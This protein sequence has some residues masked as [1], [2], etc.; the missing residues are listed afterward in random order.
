[1]KTL[2]ILTTIMIAF[3]LV[4]TSC[5][6]DDDF[7]QDNPD[8]PDDTVIVDDSDDT[9]NLDQFFGAAATRSFFGQV[10]D[11]NNNGI[12]GA[13]VHVGTQMVATDTNGIFSVQNVSVNEQFAYLR[14]TAFGYVT[15]GR[16]LRPTDGVN[17]VKV[18]LLSADVT[19]TVTSGVPE[20]VQLG[21]GTSVALPGDYIDENGNPYTGSVDVILDFLDPASEDLDAVM[22]GMLYAEDVAGD[23]VYLETF[24]MISVELRDAS[25]NELNIDPNSPAE[26]RFPLDPAL[27]G[28]APAT[29]PLWSFDDELGYWI[30]DGEATLQGNEYVGMVSH[31][32]FWNCDAPF[33]VVDFCTTVLDDNGNPLANTTV[34]I[35]SPNTPYPRSG[36]TDQNGQVC[37]KVPSGL[38]MTIEVVD[39]CGNPIFSDVIGPFAGATTYGPIS[40]NPGSSTSQQVI[41][42]FNDCS[43]S[44]I[45]DGYVVLDYGGNI[46]Y[47]PVTAGFFDI[48]L[49]SCPASNVFT[50]EAIDITNQQSSGVI[51]Y[52]FTPPTTSLGTI[53]SCNAVSEYIEWEIEGVQHFLTSPI[54]TFDNGNNF[55][56]NASNGNDFFYMSSSDTTVGTYT[57]GNG[58]Q[59]PPGSFEME[60]YEVLS[61]A[62][63]DYNAPINITFQLNAFGAVGDYID[64]TFTGTYSDNSAVVQPVSGSLHVIRD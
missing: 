54:N 39:L 29:I 26:L 46:F 33:P 15:S 44:P 45:T 16:A 25:G 34:T 60:M 12:S 61:Q 7:T 37:G 32:S 6:R 10:V 62:D 47:E 1:M 57:W 63:I 38:T 40:V 42:N 51:N 53:T 9:G 36:V 49:I 55:S 31:F 11:E 52:A 5:E 41:G 22:P 20:T 43:N 64:I 14:V 23:E 30:E 35:T 56:V 28:V 3:T 2:R 27:Q 48:N 50:L 4:F 58:I 19:A 59:A 21:N 18:M 8:I 24:G 13:L 17:R